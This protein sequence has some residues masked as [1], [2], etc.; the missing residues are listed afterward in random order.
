MF[1]TWRHSTFHATVRKM[2]PQL[3]GAAL[4]SPDA[5]R[6]RL[7]RCAAWVRNGVALSPNAFQRPRSLLSTQVGVRSFA[8]PLHSGA[9]AVQRLLQFFFLEGLIEE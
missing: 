1:L 7:G 4:K 6:L 3:C 9:P 5:H 8:R 2:H